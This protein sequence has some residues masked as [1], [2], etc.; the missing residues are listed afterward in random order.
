M[1]AQQCIEGPESHFLWKMSKLPARSKVALGLTDLF[2]GSDYLQAW[3][4][5]RRKWK[6][7]T[8]RYRPRITPNLF[9]LYQVSEIMLLKKINFEK[10]TICRR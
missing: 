1:K 4:S 6:K 3:L 9:P 10:Y 8:E 7:T 5:Q 2:G